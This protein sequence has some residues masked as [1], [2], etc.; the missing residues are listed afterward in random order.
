MP[1]LGRLIALMAREAGEEE[2]TMMQIS[3]LFHLEN[4]PITTSDLAKKRRV[5]LQ[6]ASALVQN[7]VERG[8]IIRMPDPHDRRQWLLQITPEGLARAQ[9]AKTQ[10]ANYLAGLL[11]ALSAEEIQAAQIFLPALYRILM[12]QMAIGDRK[13]TSQDSIP[14]DKPPL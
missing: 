9:G 3:V 13:S 10:A 6:A 8:W 14:E 2:T 11:E 4:N 7:M 12:Q 5:S 1:N